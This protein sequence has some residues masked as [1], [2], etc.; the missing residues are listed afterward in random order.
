ME[1]KPDSSVYDS[2]THIVPVLQGNNTNININLKN[3]NTLNHV[4]TSKLTNNVT[5]NNTICSSSKDHPSKA[6]THNSN[7]KNKLLIFHQNIR[8]LFNKTEE[9]V[10][11]W[12]TEAP[13]ILCLSEHHLLNQEINNTW[14]Q[15]YNLGASYC[16]KNR[17]GGGVGIFIQKNLAYLKIE[18]DEFCNDLDMEVC[19]V[20]LHFSEITFYILCIYRP[21]SGN[22]SY[23][24]SSLESVLNQLFSNSNNIIIC[25]DIN[26]NYL[27]NTNNK[28]HL[29]S[30]LASYNLYSI[31]DFPTRISS[32]SSTAIDN[33]FI[34]TFKN[35][36]FTVKPLPNGLSD[37]D[38]QMLTLNNIKI[39][40]SKAHCYLQRSINQSSIFE[41][42]LH[43]SNESWEDIFTDD[44]PDVIFNKF[45]NTYLRIFYQ[46]FPFKKVYYNHI[47]KPWISNG[48]KISCQHK[49][50]LYLL[51]RKTDNPMLKSHYKLYCK[52]L[53]KVIKTAKK[54]Y[55]DKRI[56]NSN[57]TAKTLWSIV[58]T[59]T[60][61]E[62][63]K[64]EP[65][66]SNKRRT[67]NEYKKLANDFNTY[68][69]NINDRRPRNNIAT[70][71][72]ALNYL[73]NNFVKPFPS[74]Q[75]APVTTTE[76]K[77]IIK[78]LKWKNSHGYDE[79][80]I[81]ILKISL[82]FI[83]SPLTYIC[84]KSLVSGL[85]PTRLKYSQINPVFKKGNKSEMSNYRPIS[86]LTSFSKIFE[87]IIYNRLQNHI[88]VNNIL[89]KEQHGF[90]NKFSTQTASFE[91]INNILDALNN[92]MKVGGI[93]CDLTK[94]FDYVNHDILLTKLK[95]YGITGK[96]NNLIKSYLSDRYQRVLIKNNYSNKCFSEWGK[97]KQGVPQGSIL[98][99]LFFLLYINDLPG[100]INDTSKPT[101]FADD[102]SIIFTH[103]NYLDLKHEIDTV[104]MKIIKWFETNS[105]ILNFDK[106][107]FMHF[108]TRPNHEV[109]L[110]ISYNTNII[111]ATNTTN[112]LGLSLDSS[113][114]WKIHIKHLSSKLNSAC[115]LIR[116]LRSVISRKNL[117]TIYFSYVH[118]IMTYGIIFWGSSPLSDTIFKLQKRIIRIMM[119]ITNRQ[120]C[121]DLFKELSILP[122]HSQYIMSLSLFVVG[123]I[124]KF[125]YNSEIHS[126]NT[127][128][129]FDLFL[130]AAKLSKYQKGARYSGIQIFNHLPQN[131]KCLSGNVKKFKTALKEFLLLGS[132]YTL[133]EYTNW[134]TRSDLSF[135]HSTM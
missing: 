119:N 18:L 29:D 86:L 135:W 55:Y 14:I 34:D 109:D 57:N 98:G 115:Y 11:S 112:F 27:D 56:L 97:I 103:T 15:N 40:S 75:L 118:S 53:T 20:Q 94:A 5:H 80:P 4:H 126:I 25:G 107:N 128:H 110:Q 127:R 79:I 46:S 35:T 85:F 133:N 99:P 92:N 9:L 91:L 64:C 68:F 47:N 38:A 13:H 131:I 111:S 7:S 3:N 132:F 44:N 66:L 19:A 31:V 102:T 116:S 16:R 61:K 78:S 2:F 48:I 83:T 1:L 88:A 39:Q 113:L 12:S 32:C 74:I 28:L 65:I 24:L 42:K 90:R 58:K 23:F 108:M 117:R 104:I 123:N 10:I 124:D 82:S 100:L 60:K 54:L 77:D 6:S 125:K 49:R 81:K 95:F 120:S 30:L 43:L 52:I 37:H 134:S 121:R 36:E 70:T 93:F 71:D 62:G 33:I 69:L 114:T 89:A 105:L 84:N 8:G 41:F 51:C 21:P 63:N 50:N 87:K 26:I 106:T 129:R 73:Q 17:K 67:L 59:E 76:M 96:A 72:P 45:L 122:L 130:P 101:V 22:F